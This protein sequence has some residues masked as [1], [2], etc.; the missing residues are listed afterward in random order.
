MLA[1]PSDTLHEHVNSTTLLVLQI[2]RGREQGNVVFC[3][4]DPGESAKHFSSTPGDESD[5]GPGYVR[6]WT[7]RQNGAQQR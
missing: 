4:G 5:A 3:A 7:P 6:W 2:Q 1:R